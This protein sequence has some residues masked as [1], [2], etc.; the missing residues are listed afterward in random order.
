[1]RISPDDPF[2][3]RTPTPEVYPAH[4]APCA[5][6]VDG[7]ILLE[8]LQATVHAGLDDEIVVDISAACPEYEPGTWWLLELLMADIWPTSGMP[9]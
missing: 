2:P 6:K 8:W 4:T 5:S 9:R 7:R 3:P 1:M